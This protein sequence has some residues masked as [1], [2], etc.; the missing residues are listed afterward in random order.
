MREILKS[1]LLWIASFGYFVDLYDLV[2][3][4]VV[5]I[6]SLKSLGYT[7]SELFSV[8]ATLLNIQTAGLLVGGLLWGLLG[9]KR[10]RKEA[11]FGSIMI[12]SF[13]TFMN[14][15]V[16]SFEAYASLRFIAGIGLAGELGA[17]VTIISECV[18]SQSRGLGT[19]FIAAVG[20]VGAMLSSV[21]NQKISW[22]HGYQIGG[23]LGFALLLARFQ[24]KESAVYL[25]AKRSETAKGIQWGSLA[26]IFS[27][28][29][30]AKH[31]F[32]LLI[33]GVPVWYVA[34]ILTYFAPELA[35]AL[36]VQG[37]VTAGTTIMMGYLGAIVGDILS[38]LVSQKL[39]SRKKTVMYFMVLGAV[40]AL[41]HP[42]FSEGTTPNEFYFTRFIIGF[43]NGFF[44][45]LIAWTAELYGTNLRTTMT[46]LISNLIRASVIPL[47][48]SF[49]WLA[50]IM[51]MLN[52]STLIGF[53]CFTAA[54]Y[55]VTRL[56]E[57]FHVK[58]EFLEK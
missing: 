39:K 19:A 35:K 32:F 1:K 10:G 48:L 57:T 53:I 44:A 26:L 41:A 16:H 34:G 18:P 47:T 4:G 45:I 5:R 37:E 15:S 30:R 43:G 27:S 21:V 58:I 50:P 11:L 14:G 52:A 7:G 2:L 46:V 29:I 9:D 38:G 22:Q 28:K 42:L 23:L 17:A 25:T 33:A 40:L 54:L 20:F 51:G 36:H 55:A 56:P 12:Y 31:F 6:E 8:G 3:Y 49:K 24:V 13:A